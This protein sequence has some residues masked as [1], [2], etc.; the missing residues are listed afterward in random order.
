MA[1]NYEIDDII[2][3]KK[4]HPCGSNKWKIIRIGADVKLECMN[5]N[6][7]IS[8]SRMKFNKSVKGKIT[9]N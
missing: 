7:I 8:F 3:M 1:D 9:D 4:G 5:F 6:R 2:M